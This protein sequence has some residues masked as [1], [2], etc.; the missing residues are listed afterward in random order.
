MNK[1]IEKLKNQFSP[2]N[3]Y[4]NFGPFLLGMDIEGIKGTNC[5]ITF[6][7]P[8]TAIAGYNGAGKSTI[9]QIALC[10]YKSPSKEELKRK[11]LKDFFVKTLL[12]K[13]PYDSSAQITAIYAAD[14]SSAPSQITLFPEEDGV[15][16]STKKNT[17]KYSSDRWAG[18][19]HQPEKAAYYYGMSYFIPY[20]EQNSNLLRDSS[21]NVAKTSR[22]SASIVKKVASILSIDYIN[23]FNNRVT[24]ESREE[25]VLSA[26]KAN[27][28]YSE[29]HMGCGEG[30]LLKL[31]NALENAPEKSLFVIEEPETAL[32]QLAQHKLALYL[33]DV[34]ARKKHQIIFTTHSPEIQKALPQEARKYIQRNDNGETIVINSPS[35][36]QIENYLSGGHK[37]RLIL[38]TEDEIGALYIREILRAYALNVFKNSKIFP[39]KLSCVE[40]KKY[41]AQSQ[42]CGINIFGVLDENKFFSAEEHVIAFPEN[43]APEISFFTDEL[44][45]AAIREEF[46]VDCAQLLSSDIDHHELFAAIAKQ[47][48]EDPQYVK[49]W[50]I[51]KYVRNKGCAYFQAIISQVNAWLAQ[52][53]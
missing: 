4:S 19:K 9:A 3:R 51:K 36:S 10:M 5:H 26:A 37:K 12:D 31:V 45:Q 48:D 22:F 47:T 41:V 18:Y 17:V 20:Q 40:V 11:Y 7:F 14:E 8:I 27:V 39:M 46:Q 34:C 50:C 1:D 13:Q 28:T 25:R 2:K 23:L 49:N 6:D 42:S 35:I 44:T 32:H 24:N 53:N 15:I 33:L 52:S 38:V 43:T 30:R 16:G 21:A 29:N